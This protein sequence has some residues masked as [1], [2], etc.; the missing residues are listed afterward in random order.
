ML[1]LKVQRKRFSAVAEME[2]STIRPRAGA[3]YA[4]FISGDWPTGR[5]SQLCGQPAAKDHQ[6]LILP[7]VAMPDAS[8]LIVRS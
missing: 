2:V 4:P 7:A 5:A 8:F 3:D 1:C 6:R